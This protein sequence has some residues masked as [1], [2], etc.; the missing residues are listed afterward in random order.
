[1][2][3]RFEVQGFKQFGHLIL[4]FSRIRDYT[5]NQNCIKNGLVKNGIIYGRNASGKTNL[6]LALFDIIA[7]LT[8]KNSGESFYNYYLKADD[9]TTKA[10]FC[11]EF[12]FEGGDSVVYRYQK[13]DH[14]T[15][16][17]E[18]L[19]VNGQL[20]L[21]WPTENHIF[22]DSEFLKT[23]RFGDLEWSVTQSELSVVKYIFNNMVP[24]ANS[25]LSKL[26]EFVNGMLW[27][28]RND[29]NNQY[30]GLSN[31]REDIYDYIV[32]NDLVGD[33]ERFLHTFSEISGRLNAIKSPDGNSLLYF[34]Y[35]KP[36]PVGSVAS[37]GTRALSLFYYWLKHKAEIKFLFID[38]FDAFYHY[39]L[40]ERILSYLIKDF[41]G[42][43]FV[44]THNINL[45]TNKIIRPD[46]SFIVRNER[47]HS[48][49]ELTRRE[50]RQGNNLE[51]L[52]VSGEFDG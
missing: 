7:N 49:P 44:T 47:I 19:E 28:Q 22:I 11:Y 37:S 3:K 31:S 36:L 18:E 25:A 15:L 13:G 45:L 48:L 23:Y 9:S 34:D 21:R 6:G 1:M 52:Y 26:K 42:Q 24:Q 32:R 5:F 29:M 33:F 20:V 12:V 27:F 8:D 41:G 50:L 46:C 14:H 2:L 30:I 40:S 51:R 43:A 16:Y 38:E 17:G 39:D 10:T 4:D 35:E